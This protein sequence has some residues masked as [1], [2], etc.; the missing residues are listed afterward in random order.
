MAYGTHYCHKGTFVIGF[1]LKVVAEPGLSVIALYHRYVFGELR[2]KCSP[3]LR[4][5]LLVS[6]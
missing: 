1:I 4:P 2:K 6:I 5:E 3:F